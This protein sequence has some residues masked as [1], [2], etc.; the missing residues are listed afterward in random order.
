MSQ[1]TVKF[2]TGQEIDIDNKEIENGAI[3]FL[4]YDND[5][6]T[7]AYDMNNNRYFIDYPNLVTISELTTTWIPKAG[8]IVI[9]TDATIEDGKPT[10][11]VKIGNGI[12][13]ALALPY[14]GDDTEIAELRQTVQTLRNEF[15]NHKND[16]LIHHRLQVQDTT[17]IISNAPQ[18]P[19]E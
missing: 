13:N 6:I 1:P 2:Y 14:I 18:L 11:Y 8:E 10:P 9:V 7:V 17:Y 4:P 12:T 19:N 3:Y 16:G 15:D 5:K